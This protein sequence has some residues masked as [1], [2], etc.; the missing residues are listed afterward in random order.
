[1]GR[2]TIPPSVAAA[3][4]ALA[5][6]VGGCS[7]DDP[8][9]G[10][11]AGTSSTTTTETAAPA[12]S[13]V[14]AL[15]AL[16]RPLVLAHAGGD[17]VHP[18]DTPYG[19]D[20]SAEAGVDALD[21]DV[22]LSADG[23]LVVQHDDTVDRTTEGSGE[24]GSMTYDQLHALDAAYWFT[25]GCTCT[26]RPDEEYV[27]RGVRT[28]EVDPPEGSEPD[29]FAITSFEQIAADHP[30]HVLNIEIKG[31][32]PEAIPAAEELARLVRE[33]DLTDRVVVTA[34]DDAVAEAFAAAAPG[35]AITPGLGAT[36]A[37]VLQGTLPPAGR[38]ILQVPPEFEGI[39]VVTPDMV[40]RAH[41]DGLVVWVWPNDARWETTDGYGQL[42]DM[43]VDGLNAADPATA[44]DVVAART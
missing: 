28:G 18:H 32:A 33:M 22:Q 14:S 13:T 30:D 26:D 10:D 3:V 15:L 38:T 37:Y 8:A 31:E 39:E 34:F 9:E 5:L 2:S 19:F 1:M 21:M 7:S 12:A 42:L 36:T 17:D 23:V 4:A 27:L 25:E 24:V 11:D 20:R 40:A 6:L 29:D 43:G 16:D 35:A 41:R 44:V